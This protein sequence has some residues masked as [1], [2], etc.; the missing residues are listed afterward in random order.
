MFYA[1][2]QPTDAFS[3]QAGKLFTLIG[4]EGTYTYQ[5][6]DISRGLV[7]NLE[8]VISRGVQAN[9]TQGA[10]TGELQFSDGYYS[11]RFSW[12]E[13]SLAYTINPTNTITFVGGGN[14]GT[15]G[16]TSSFADAYQANNGAIGN[17]IYTYSNAPWTV[18][19][20]V[21]YQEVPSSSKLG[22][23]SGKTYSGAVLASY[24]FN[25][26]FSLGG[27]FEYLDSTGGINLLG[28]GAGS[29]AY[30][31]TVTPTYQYN[32]VF[33]RADLSYVG[34]TSATAGD[35]FGSDGTDKDQFRG[36]VET[37][38]LF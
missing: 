23:S 3:I 4:A 18:T 33:L 34:V 26:N 22:Y 6:I 10:F 35:A 7:W 11:N 20:Y 21:Q 2:L 38:V 19:G 15:T 16:P 5:N 30:T 37:G 24:Q 27:R 17:V 32:R 1:K 8:P 14:L 36:I 12:I 29:K 28:Y 13:G 9:Y 25:P 31:I